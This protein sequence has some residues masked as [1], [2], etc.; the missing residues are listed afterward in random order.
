MTVITIPAEKGIF[1]SKDEFQL[2]FN[3][4]RILLGSA[5]L[6]GCEGG[7]QSLSLALSRIQK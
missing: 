4:I 7:L 5:E 2:D 3:V 6:F 1:L